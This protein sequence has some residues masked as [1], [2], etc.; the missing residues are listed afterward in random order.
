MREVNLDRIKNCPWDL[1]F[2]EKQAYEMCIEAIEEDG[3]LLKDVRWDELNLTK[4]QIYKLCLIAVRQNGEALDY[5][6]VQTE[7]IC[8]EALKQDK[9]AIKYVK[10]KEKYEN[11][12]N[13][14]YLKKQGEAKEVMA[15]KENGKW[16]FTVGC[17]EDID[18]EEF[19]YRIYNTDG[20]FDLERGINVHR[21]VYV[22]FLEQFK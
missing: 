3:L 6:K 21:Q 17:Q 11:I 7:E 12:F 20:G 2:A 10:D 16:L 8:I 15:I 14:K 4:K 1:E 18:L 5:V 13:I 9:Y 22:D 19:I